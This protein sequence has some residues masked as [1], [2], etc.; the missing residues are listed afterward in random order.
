MPGSTCIVCGHTRSASH[1]FSMH[2]FPVDLVKRSKW[3][4]ALKLSEVDIT[5]HSRICSR[6]FLHGN[7]LVVPS[8][9]LGNDLAS[10]INQESS[11]GERGLKRQTLSMSPPP[12]PK[13]SQESS[14]SSYTTPSPKFLRTP[15]GEPLLS[16]SDYSVHELYSNDNEKSTSS[17]TCSSDTMVSIA[18]L[19]HVN[20]LEKR[21]PM[22][23]RIF[24]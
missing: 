5:E 21:S 16:D 20:S 4:H 1:P 14:C 22:K 23:N 17:H 18:L 13:Q 7:I 11:R 9:Y 12:P 3:L 10:P 2:R 8:L 19:S 6:H 24:E 15:I